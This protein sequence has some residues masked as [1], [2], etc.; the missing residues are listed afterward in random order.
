MSP[1]NLALTRTIEALVKALLSIGK[2]LN[3]TAIITGYPWQLE[4]LKAMA[5]SN[6]WSELNIL[7]AAT[8]QGDEWEIVIISLVKT[9]THP[10]FIGNQFRANVVATRAREARYLFGNWQ[11]LWGRQANNRLSA[12]ETMHRL[13]QHM[14]YNPGSDTTPFVVLPIPTKHDS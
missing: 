10:G 12:Y 14:L 9:S 3:S 5:K 8:C 1:V 4:K 6:G 7:S 2:P 13:I 11:G